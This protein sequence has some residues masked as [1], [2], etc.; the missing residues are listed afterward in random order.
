MD[1]LQPL[2]TD[3]GIEFNRLDEEKIDKIVEK[4]LN[5]NSNIKSDS[6]T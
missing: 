2:I 3:L 6:N 1:I 4:I 5:L